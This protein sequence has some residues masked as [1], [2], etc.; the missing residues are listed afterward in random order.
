MAYANNFFISEADL[1]DDLEGIVFHPFPVETLGGWA[2]SA[3]S[4]ITRLGESLARASGLEEAESVRF[5]F[6]RLSLLLMRGNTAL[7]INCVPSQA[8][9]HLDG[10]L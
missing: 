2:E 4:Q 7:L 8:D 5:L 1:Q 9:P 10:V 3:V 6:V